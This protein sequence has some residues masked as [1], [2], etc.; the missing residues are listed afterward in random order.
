M[1]ATPERDRFWRARVP[2]LAHPRGRARV[3][4]VISDAH[5]GLVKAIWRCFQGTVWQR[6]S[7][8]MVGGWGGPD[9]HAS[10]GRGSWQRDL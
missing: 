5:A 4:L 10:G 1:S 2:V 7:V 8:D 9:R 3:R 6:S